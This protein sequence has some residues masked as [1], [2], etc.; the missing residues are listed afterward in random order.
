M[1]VPARRD[2]ECSSD[3]GLGKES[4]AKNSRVGGEGYITCVGLVQTGVGQTSNRVRWV[5]Y[6]CSLM[7]TCHVV[8]LATALRKHVENP[9]KTGVKRHTVDSVA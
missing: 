3:S 8:T 9:T 7:L 1:G 5:P 2:G 6:R 4:L